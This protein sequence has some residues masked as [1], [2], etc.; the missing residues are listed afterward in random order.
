MKRKLIDRP[1]VIYFANHLIAA[2]A[3]RMAWISR[4]GRSLTVEMDTDSGRL[5]EEVGAKRAAQRRIYDL[6]KRLR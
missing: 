5:T 1:H 2:S 3:F 6:Q 4:R